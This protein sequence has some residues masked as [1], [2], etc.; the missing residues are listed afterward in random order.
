MSQERPNILWYCTDAQRFDTI[1]AL[2]NPAIST[3]NIDR[4]TGSGVAFRRTYA[5]STLCTPSRASFLTGRYCAAH[6]VFRNGARFF[7]GAV[8]VPLIMSWQGK[9][10]TDVQSDALVEL[11]DVAPTLLEAAGIEV[12]Y[13][14]QGRS[15]VPILAGTAE[16]HSHRSRVVSEFYDSC[17]FSEGSNDPTQAFM[18]FDGR[19]KMVTYRD[20]DLG[21]LFDLESD[22][23]EFVDLWDDP[24]AAATKLTVMRMHVDAIL[25]AISSGPRRS[26]RY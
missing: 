14:M 12:P 16:A 6:Q 5:Q 15:L 19:Y 18:S 3:P 22:A 2:G 1:R 7:E 26:T 20:H 23:G 4:L 21:E 10:Q 24:A 9:F 13:G 8:R 17:N 25:G 11:I